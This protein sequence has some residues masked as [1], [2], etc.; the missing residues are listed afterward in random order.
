MNDKSTFVIGDVKCQSNKYCK[1]VLDAL[2]DHLT[3]GLP[4]LD[5]FEICKNKRIIKNEEETQENIEFKSES[6]DET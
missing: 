6:E 2:V 5:A 3:M 1:E 4:L